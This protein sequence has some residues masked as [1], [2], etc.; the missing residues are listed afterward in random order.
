MRYLDTLRPLFGLVWR[1]SPP[2]FLLTFVL[3]ILG[4]LL[5]VAG[6][7]LTAKLIDALVS[8]VQLP[9]GV[10]LQTL[11]TYFVI[12]IALFAGLRVLERLVNGLQ[13]SVS[14]LFQTKVA[15]YVELQISEKAASLDLA[16]FEDP[17]FHNRL[18]TASSEASYRPLQIVMQLMQ[19]CTSATMLVSVTLILML[20]QPWI[21]PVILTAALVTFAVSTHFSGERAKLVIGRMPLSRRKM[22]ISSLLTADWTVKEVRL[23]SLQKY[24]LPNLRDLQN[25]MYDQDK[26][27]ER[28][29]V[30]YTTLTEVFMALVTAALVGYISFAVL[31]QGISVGDFS[32]YTGAVFQ[33]QAGLLGLLMAL[34]Q[35]HGHTIFVHDLFDFLA[36]EP[37][38]EAQ[39]N[40]TREATA[41]PN[42]IRAFPSI[43]FRNVSFR[44]TETDPY[45]VRNLSFKIAPGEKV[46]LV[47]ENGAGK[48]TL[49]KL[50]SGLYEPTEGQILLDGVDVTGLERD[51]L[52]S[53]LGVIFQDYLIYHLPLATNIGVG[54]VEHLDD[55]ARI[56]RAAARSGLD[57]LVATL[58]GGYDTVLERFIDR[59]HELSGGQRQLVA[60]TRALMRDAPILVLDEPTSALDPRAEETF[61]E[62]LVEEQAYLAQT[63]VF[64]SHR[65]STI[66]RAERILV[67]EDGTLSEQGSHFEL[68]ALGGRYATLFDL[69]AKLYRDTPE[70][71]ADA[72][73]NTTARKDLHARSVS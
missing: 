37:K 20:W 17:V 40:T 39:R 30:G 53:Y 38:V 28:R 51:T 66:R 15:N 11:P 3:A 49:V 45:S 31:R 29:R 58:P 73:V 26:G 63:V 55:G 64:I 46:A 48:T 33:F 72:A 23:F 2:F 7:A 14:G 12:L 21:P 35:I 18:T 57:K 34:S 54:R 44:Y 9:Q 6:I 19:V 4:G 69:Q 43:E 27:L 32:L 56:R 61:F 65:F 13:G 16:Y 52:R 42:G 25:E 10:T 68:M 36:T 1:S 59:G 70:P 50:L 60:I 67:L 71:A 62:R 24:L 22:Y 8:A 41:E 5:P 47:G